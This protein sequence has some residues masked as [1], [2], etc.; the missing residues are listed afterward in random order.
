MTAIRKIEALVAQR[1]VRDLLIAHSYR[2]THPIVKRGIDDF[3][4]SKARFW[5]SDCD[6]ADFTTPSFDQRHNKAIRCERFCLR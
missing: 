5:I 3:V 1:E 6:V 2:E 4:V